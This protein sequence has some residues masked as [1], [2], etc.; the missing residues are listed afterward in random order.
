MDAAYGVAV[1]AGML[2]VVNPCG[3]ALLPAYA[4][5]VVRDS[6]DVTPV[7]ALGRA[8]SL[9]AAMALGFV[10][11]FGVFGALAAPVASWVAERLP[12]LT[13]VIGLALVALGGWLAS[14]RQVP[15]PVPKLRQAPH[16][17]R[18]LASMVIFGAA[19]AIA[20]L[21]CTI[22]PFL[23][24]VVTSFTTSPARGAGLFLAYA[25][26]MTVVVAAVAVVIALARQAGLSRIRRLTPVLTRVTGAIL[27]LTGLYVAWYGWYEIRVLA[28]SSV[29][30]PVVEG[31]ADLQRAL[32]TAVDVI[33]VV[34]FGAIL[35]TG[36][37]VAA[38]WR[39]IRR[40]A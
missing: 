23:G 28:D 26:G 32:S 17:R 1:A 35:A 34:G 20:S 40:R 9:T 30:D 31:A 3:F 7:R 22:G 29:D 2:A 33:G 10:A 15:S 14:G 4:S 6:D 16:L 18:R 25:A 39:L 36:L 13:I 24:V 5:L 8:L 37:A 19:F 12:W 11:V 38:L 27:L 21:G